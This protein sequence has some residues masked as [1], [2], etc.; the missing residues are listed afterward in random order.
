MTFQENDDMN[1]NRQINERR[2]GDARWGVGSIL[3]GS[4]AALA[5]IFGIFYMLSDRNPNM[6]NSGRP[7]ITTNSSPVIAPTPIPG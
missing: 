2:R 5:L 6:A 3:L 7:A 1:I 4:L